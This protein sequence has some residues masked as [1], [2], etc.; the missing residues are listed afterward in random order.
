MKI[1]R[2]KYIDIIPKEQLSIVGSDIE[3]N[4]LI[5]ERLDEELLELKESKFKDQYEYAD[6]LEVLYT[7][8]EINGI[9]R[10]QM[11]EVRLKK[12]EKLGGFSNGLILK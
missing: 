3:R 12:K 2:D 9:S 1:I 11:E 7:L 4:G 8:G 6:V 10:E 5:I